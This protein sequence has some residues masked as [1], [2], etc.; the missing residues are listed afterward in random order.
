MYFKTH[1]D[2]SLQTNYTRMCNPD[3]QRI[4][5]TYGSKQY[6]RLAQNG[7]WSLNNFSRFSK[8]FLKASNLLGNGNP[9]LSM[10]EFWDLYNVYA[11]D[12]SEQANVSSTN[13]LTIYLE[14][15]NVPWAGDVTL[16]NPREIDAF[17]IVITETR[18][19][20]DCVNKTLW[21]QEK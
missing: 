20:I 15:R 19:E 1:T 7:N 13:S 11:I 5:I 6:P 9:A 3:V 18:I 16:A 17:L 21:R 14:R 4:T 2:D 8:E 10:E 12:V